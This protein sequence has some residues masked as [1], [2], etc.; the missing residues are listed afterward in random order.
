MRTRPSKAR[1]EIAKGTQ[2]GGSRTFVTRAC[3]AFSSI[4]VQLN[5]QSDRSR[6]STL[7]LKRFENAE[8]KEDDFS[9]FHK[10]W[11]DLVDENY[12]DALQARTIN[13]IPTIL[14]NAKTF[15]KAA[16][17]EV[18]SQRTGDQIGVMLAGA[19]SLMSSNLISYEDAVKFVKSKNWDEEK[20][21]QLTKDELQLFS[22]LSGEPLKIEGEM[23]SYERSIGELVM[24]AS[25]QHY[26]FRLNIDS[27]TDLLKRVGIIVRGDRV[28]FSNNSPRIKR[29]INQ[30]AW[31]NNHGRILERLDGAKKET[32]RTYYPGHSSRGVS[33]PIELFSEGFEIT[34]PPGA[35]PLAMPTPSNYTSAENKN[36][37]QGH[38]KFLFSALV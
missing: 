22:I 28:N 19:Y 18:K 16:S 25:G 21:M 32:S 9:K 24:I 2:S 35:A 10:D 11:D 33:V 37:K 30:T 20:G 31:A 1:G 23:S 6:F 29:I 8:E 34:P 17:H 27:V 5:Q 12:V 7:S 14:E 36:L 26:D 38:I 4:G 3:F 15:S 13:L